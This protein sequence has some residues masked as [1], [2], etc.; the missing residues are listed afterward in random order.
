M[1]YFSEG[2]LL[3]VLVPKWR[4]HILVSLSLRPP[5]PPSFSLSLT[6]SRLLTTVAQGSEP[7]GLRESRPLLLPLHTDNNNNN[8]ESSGP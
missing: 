4:H 5:L 6:G 1:N 2:G 8:D 3:P 7:M